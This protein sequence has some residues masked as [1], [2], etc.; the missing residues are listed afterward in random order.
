MQNRGKIL[1]ALTLA[2]LGAGLV[3]LPQF[4]ATQSKPSLPA[5][6]QT[7]KSPEE[8]VPAYHA[9]PPTGP[10]PPTMD[11]ASFS[12]KQ[13]FNAYL[14]AARVKKVLY[15]QP[16]Y[17]HCDRSHGHTSLLD[18]FASRH[19]AGCEMCMREAFYSYEQTRKGKTAA[20]VREGIM[21]GAWQNVD[22]AK[23]QKGYLPSR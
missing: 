10:L 18:C 15:Q 6:A 12:E 13:T 16:C 19:G 5:P 11:P 21:H 8:P 2:V 22:L 1:T 7:A 23:Y 17:C 14:L 9:Q 3:L 20:Q 4:A